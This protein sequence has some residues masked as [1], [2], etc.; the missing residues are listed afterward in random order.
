[1][2]VLRR[3]QIDEGR[4]SNRSSTFAVPELSALV[5]RTSSSC[6][7]DFSLAGAAVLLV[8]DA[9]GAVPRAVEEGAVPV[10]PVVATP[11]PRFV[12]A[13]GV[14]AGTSWPPTQIVEAVSHAGIFRTRE[15]SVLAPA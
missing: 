5:K 12:R 8:A 13:R 4:P 7:R 14:D 15:R 1:M 2:T 9:A 3:V 10:D 6:R 11:A